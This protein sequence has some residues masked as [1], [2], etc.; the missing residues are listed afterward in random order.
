MFVT[1]VHVFLQ[2]MSVMMTLVTVLFELKY[3]SEHMAIH[4]QVLKKEMLESSNKGDE[5]LITYQF[6]V[7]GIKIDWIQFSKNIL[8]TDTKCTVDFERPN[9]IFQKLNMID[10]GFSVYSSDSCRKSSRIYIRKKILVYPYFVGLNRMV[11][12]TDFISNSFYLY[13]DNQSIIL[14]TS[15]IFFLSRTLF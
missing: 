15:L 9:S 13:L 6:R 1:P 3:T 7:R 5:N 8:I 10:M 4:A 14:L 2:A 12:F 11:N